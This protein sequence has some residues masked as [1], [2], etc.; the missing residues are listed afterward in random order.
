MVK[1]NKGNDKQPRIRSCFSFTDVQNIIYILTH[2]YFVLIITIIHI[3]VC[4]NNNINRSV[5][6]IYVDTINR[7]TQM[8]CGI[9][10]I[11]MQTQFI[12]KL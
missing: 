3:F 5:R 12:I 8:Y 2:L 4:D 9:E 11:D 1:K 10:L 7:F 6:K